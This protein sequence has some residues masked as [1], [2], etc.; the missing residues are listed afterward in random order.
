MEHHFGVDDVCVRPYLSYETYTMYEKMFTSSSQSKLAL[1]AYARACATSMINLLAPDLCVGCGLSGALVCERC[2]HSLFVVDPLWACTIC[3]APFGWL[4]CT[5]HDRSWFQECELNAHSAQTP[6]FEHVYSACIYEKTCARLIK[7]YKDALD[8]RYAAVIAALVLCYLDTFDISAPSQV[9]A[10][11]FVPATH[12][13]YVRRGFDHME[14]I[15]RMLSYA[16]G[17]ELLDVL[18]RPKAQD[19]RLLS[20][21]ERAHNI[22]GSMCVVMPDDSSIQ[23]QQVRMLV[24]DDVITT[25]ASMKEAARVLCACGVRAVSALSFARV[26]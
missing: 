20:R 3:G 6:T 18:A 4:T 5:Q 9:D 8:M 23:L 26:W 13:A 11:C 2:F 19:Q 14:I 10:V 17:I 24:V 12:K 25:G 15:A 1:C 22:E 21:E 16:W 7:S